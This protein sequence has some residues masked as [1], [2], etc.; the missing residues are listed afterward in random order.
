MRANEDGEFVVSGEEMFVL[1]QGLFITTN[2][3]DPIFDYALQ[4]LTGVDLDEFKR[5][6]GTV[7]ALRS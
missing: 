7:D 5:M 6:M 2:H 4:A 3:L 1:R